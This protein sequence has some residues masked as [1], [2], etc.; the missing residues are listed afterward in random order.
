MVRFGLSSMNSGATLNRPW[1]SA[2]FAHYAEQ[3]PAM[4]ADEEISPASGG[5]E[6]SRE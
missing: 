5:E 2:I 6:I 4:L 3:A 1:V